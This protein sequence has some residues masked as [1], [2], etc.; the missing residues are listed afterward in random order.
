MEHIILSAIAPAVGA[1]LVT[2]ASSL[3]GGIFGNNSAKKEAAKNREFQERMARNAH[4]YEVEDLRKA[5]L[6]PVLSGLG[7]SG[8]ATPGGAVANVKDPITPAV[9]SATQ[10]MAV[11]SQMELTKQ[12]AKKADWDAYTSKIE[13]RNAFRNEEIMYKTPM[14]QIESAVA[15]GTATPIE[16]S[17]WTDYQVKLRT[18]ANLSATTAVQQQQMRL[19]LPEE[20]FNQQTGNSAT[21]M[22][23][24][25][26]FI[27]AIK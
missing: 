12:Q 20:Q 24:F 5:G 27:K 1:A 8:A 6:N 18:A 7:G 25:M 11:R 17:A 21:W 16:L 10:A 14:K 2:G 9:S 15:N 19:N 3:L 13:A 26:Q 22:K 23:N 4:Q